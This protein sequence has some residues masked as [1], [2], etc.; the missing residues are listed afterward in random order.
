MASGTFG[1]TSTGFNRP[2]LAQLIAD[3]Q[4]YML[5]GVPSLTFAAGSPELAIVEAR[6]KASNAEWESRECS[7]NSLDINNT[8]GCALDMAARLQG[9]TRLIGETD[10]QFLDRINS[11]VNGTGFVT[12]LE[13]AISQIQGNCRSVVYNN[14]TSTDDVVT[15]NPPSSFEVV[16]QGGH[17]EAIALAVWECSTGATNIGTDAVFV[18][19]AGG[20]CR[21][22]RIT[23]AT[24][25]P[26]CIRLI[27]DTYSVRGGCDNQ[28]FENIIDAA[29]EALQ[30]K[31]IN[32]GDA[33]HAGIVSGP[34][35][36]AV[37]GINIRSIE[38]A[39]STIDPI[40]GD[41]T[42]ANVTDEDWVPG[43]L[44]LGPRELATFDRNC[45]VVFAQDR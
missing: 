1:P 5:A 21:E 6:A 8:S 3:E 23:E 42:C 9:F 35:Y 19:D 45:I 25:T 36:A 33:I 26:Y 18:E 28:T 4:S 27:L 32:I 12:G 10:Q 16:Y 41:C 29:N 14:N 20:I 2:T 37:S 17:P 39:P 44:N 40:T 7:Y 43:P 31:S 38:F 24:E 11:T 30:S 15:G 22:V 13:T 34:I